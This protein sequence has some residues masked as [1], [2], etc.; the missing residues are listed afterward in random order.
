MTDWQA[1]TT[2]TY[3]D[4]ATALAEYFKGIGPR[5]IYID[6]AFKLIGDMPQ[7]KVV[8][9]GCGDGR[10]AA[11]IVTKTDN[12]VGFDP[13]R[14]MI[15]LARKRL[16]KVSFEISDALSFDYPDNTDII[17][18]FSSLLHIP[19]ED[20]KK[21][22]EKVSRSLRSGGLLYITLKESDTYEERVK[23]DQFGSRVF[24]YYSTEDIIAASNNH[25]DKVIEIHETIGHTKWLELGLRRT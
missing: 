16:P 18:A 17:F 10:D 20:L 23:E 5:T 4:S 9:I 24:Y 25:F 13:S 22:I 6:L 15:A 12:Y 21:V 1:V 14:G 19:I 8:E 11:A 3:D 2:Q 7:A